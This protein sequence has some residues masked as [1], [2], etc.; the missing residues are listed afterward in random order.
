[1]RALGA[2]GA[3]LLLM[4]GAGTAAA[5]MRTSEQP[6][7]YGSDNRQDLWQVQ[8][9]ALRELMTGSA[10]T[11]V[12]LTSVTV[13]GPQVEL[14]GATLGDSQQLCT[15]EPFRDQPTPGFCSGALIG[16]DL[17]L[18]AG[19]CLNAQSCARSL[20]VFG[21]V[22]D[23][24]GQVRTAVPADHV[25]AC[26]RVV[27]RLNGT[28]D[29]Y[30]VVQLDRPATPT[31]TPATVRTS[32]GLLAQGTALV[33][34]GSP[35]GI[36]LKLD[37]GGRVRR[38][39]E[40]RFFTAT[41]DAFGGNS[42][43]GVWD[44]GS[45]E[46]VGLLTGGET[47]YVRS[48]GCWRAKRCGE[49]E[50][51]GESVYYAHHAIQAFCRAGTDEVLCGSAPR[52]GDGYCAWNEDRS[53]CPGD[54]PTVTCGDGVC[55]AGEWRTCPDDCRLTIPPGWTCPADYYGTG[56]GCDC[57]C[58]S[59]TDPDCD[60]PEQERFG[61]EGEGGCTAARVQSSRVASATPRRTLPAD[62]SWV[63]CLLVG[64]LVASRRRLFPPM[65]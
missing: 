8:D 43:S 24:Q 33:M 57:N 60:D 14:L 18:T 1:M 58:G 6:V 3:G 65:A 7:I 54:C 38:P 16:P 12:S 28:A 42:G 31:F 64:L 22:S 39:Q 50:C 11:W 36:P 26:A 29:D 21:F 10:G 44:A 59:V 34:V 15:D 23:A 9:E 27:A 5:Q 52:C 63:G 19:H 55:G 30:A 48:G 37:A 4:A 46:L 25:F 35:S 20:F 51:L 13:S 49:T 32:Q 62:A 61:C 2:L 56:D 47:D 17:V 45:L 41:V 53:A 40:G